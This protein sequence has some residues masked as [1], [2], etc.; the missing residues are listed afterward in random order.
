MD[1]CTGHHGVIVALF[2]ILKLGLWHCHEA[3]MSPPSVTLEI[4][5]DPEH[6]RILVEW[7]V[8]KEPKMDIMFH[9]QV[10]MSEKMNIITD[11]YLR[12][13]LS[14]SRM[15]FNWTWHSLLPLECDS[16]SVRVRS[17]LVGNVPTA[18]INWSEWSPWK[19]HKGETIGQS[20]AVIYPRDRVVL[21]GSDVTFCCIP[22]QGLTVQK[23]SY[24]GNA[25]Y[26]SLNMGTDRFVISVKNVK[27]TKSDGSNVMCELGGERRNGTVLIVSRLPDEPKDFTCDTQDMQTLRCRWN[28]GGRYNFYGNLSVN[29][30]LQDWFTLNSTSCARDHCVWQIQ[31][32]Q[33]A[34]NFTLTAK[35]RMGERSINAIVYLNQRVLLLAPSSITVTEVSASHITVI[36]S[37]KADYTSLQI[38]CQVDLQGNLVNMTSQGKLPTELYSVRISRLQPYTQYN[39]RVRCMA[40]SSLAGWSSWSHPPREVRT[41][42]DAPAGALDIWRHIEEDEDRRVTLYWRPTSHFRANGRITHY[43]IQFWPLEGAAVAS[44]INVSGVNSSQISI[45]R[46]TYAIRVTAHNKA[47]VS[48]PADLRIPAHTA[49]DPDQ[50][51]AQR[52]TGKD[53]G[54]IVQ[55]K[56]NP[57]AHGYVVEW[58]AE[59]R[60][61][62]CDLQWKKYNATVY[63]DV[64]QSRVFRPG[65]R[66]QFRLYGSM[67]DGERLLV[68]VE[69]YTE[70]LASSVKPVVKIKK[71]EAR[72]I[73]LDWS[74]YPTDGS[75]EGFVTG[76]NVYVKDT[77]KDCD[78][79]K[80]HGYVQQGDSL[81]CRFYIGD[82]DNMQ[83]VISDLQPNGKYEVAVVAITGGGRRESPAEYTKAHT[84]SDT[85]AALRSIL[86]P[87][88]TISALALALLF[89]GCWKR[90][91]LKRMCLPDIPDPN[92]SY[93]FSDNGRKGTYN[94]NILMTTQYEPQK[95]DVVS[96]QENNQ[97][98]E[99]EETNKYPECQVRETYT[100]VQT[101]EESNCDK[102]F[103]KSYIPCDNDPSYK[104]QL[105]AYLEF[106]NQSYTG[107]MDDGS[108]GA[109][110]YR[111]QANT[112]QVHSPPY[113]VQS[114]DPESGLDDNTDIGYGCEPM[115]PTSVGSTT[116]IL[117]D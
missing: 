110:G 98:K 29:Y 61:P 15:S 101:T 105:P 67:K 7:K 66:Y 32:S 42:E 6:Q 75:Q 45:G 22:A 90:A 27:R 34:Y 69:G 58:C 70:E 108:D 37:L 78:L 18:E 68:K 48:P 64:I 16:H 62:H 44:D 39:V 54:V 60:S 8:S 91:W 104:A 95:V 59:P 17:A 111:P 117:I 56:Q 1:H 89:L 96:I 113:I 24:G 31:G 28:P 50:A 35:N 103:S 52:T 94:G 87:I 63:S 93:I 84:P 55:W 116:F 33:Q 80:S 82:P 40:E 97:P 13:D 41:H 38:H 83:I 73:F 57:A 74:P 81:V 106:F 72:S 51:I 53:G 20:V 86:V 36:W 115:S 19:T 43:N 99:H 107:T 4:H 76:Y 47:G 77:E 114:V 23:M 85:A 14:T 92:K 2:L 100:E 11:K 65:V 12:P 21:E 3:E 30:V 88:I 25:D 5:S 79:R 112:A 71:M 49:S 10:A 102:V 46:Q 109:P 9:V 26:Q